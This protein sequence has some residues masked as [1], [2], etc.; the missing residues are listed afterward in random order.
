MG[1]MSSDSSQPTAAATTDS[2]A[3]EEIPSRRGKGFLAVCG[4][5][6]VDGLGHL[7]AGRYRR[8]LFWFLLSWGLLAL[9]ISCAMVRAL[10]PALIVLVP[11]GALL[12][13]WCII[14][15]YLVGRRSPRPMLRFPA[16]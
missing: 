9:L 7:F 12:T 5:L 8:G 13:V 15:A 6:A 2:A 3:P 11:V 10:M 1:I 16:L 4:T 14:A